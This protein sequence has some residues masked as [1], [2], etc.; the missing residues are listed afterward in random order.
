[1]ADSKSFRRAAESL[2]VSQPTLSSQIYILEKSL[3]TTL[4]E[5]SRTGAIVTP[6][7][8]ELLAN[9]RL[10]LEEVRGLV[11]QASM[12]RHGPGGTFKIGVSPTVGPYLLPYIL[13][14][15]HREY[16]TLKLYVRE[17]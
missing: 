16:S 4:L 2:G 8:R 11:D 14:D 13:P 1:M 10:V 5:R 9:A 15:L 3:K 17:S 12:M 7:G 6:A